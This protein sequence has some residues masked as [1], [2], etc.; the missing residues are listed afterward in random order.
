MQTFTKWLEQYT[1]GSIN[2]A[3]DYIR[4]VAHRFKGKGRY[5]ISAIMDE[6][7]KYQRLNDETYLSFAKRFLNDDEIEQIWNDAVKH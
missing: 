3:I 4:S 7:S 5:M 6:L 2:D 1:D